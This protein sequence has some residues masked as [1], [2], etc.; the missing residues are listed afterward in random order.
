MSKGKARLLLELVKSAIWGDDLVKEEI[1][2]ELYE[3]IYKQAIISLPALILNKLSMSSDIRDAWKESII[4]EALFYNRYIYAQSTLPVQV[5]YIILKGTTAAQY[6]PHPEYRTMGDI[7]IITRKEDYLEA[8]SMLVD[9][10]YQEVT[11]THEA[12]TGRHR[13][14]VKNGIH[15][16][17]HLFFS[18][19]NDTEQAKYLDDVIIQNINPTHM[20]PDLINGLVLLEHISQ[21]LENGLG[22]RQIIDWMMYVDKCLPDDKWH[23]FE[24]MSERIGLKTLAIV[25]TRMCEIYLGLPEHSWCRGADVNLCSQLMDYVL[26]SGNFGNKRISDSDVGENV[27]AI[28][29]S[30]KATFRLLQNR[31][32]VNWKAAQ[33]NRF[34]RPFAWI[35]QMWRYIVK[36]LA[37][38]DASSKIKREYKAAKKRNK[39]LDTL[40]VRQAAK[41]NII[42]K[43]G[44]F[45]KK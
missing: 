26:R 2:A 40:G 28:V 17:V 42:F 7:D 9:G 23:E 5:P 6:Y 10:G 45:I 35:Y 3:E 14:F 22:L 43:N 33:K 27:F 32:V 38:E 34:L 15:V 11:G 30:P 25:T 4:Q 16:E 20:L 8:C 24:P 13:G 19:L 18:L 12:A 36:G 44:E 31:G 29:R 39:M 1:S 41:G 37:R 21:H